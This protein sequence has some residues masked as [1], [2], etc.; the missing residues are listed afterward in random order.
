LRALIRLLTYVRGAWVTTL[1]AYAC[2]VVNGVTTL[3]VPWLLGVA[4]DAGISQNDLGKVAQVSLGILG[5][6]ALRGLA[7]FG[8]GYLAESSAQRVS[9]LLR[10][11]LYVHLQKLSFSFHDQAQTGELMSRTTADVEAVRNFTG[12]G[13]LNLANI[14]VLMVGVLIALLSMNTILA[15]VSLTIIPVLVW[16]TER[17]TRTIR[18]MQT[19][20]QEGLAAVATR[21]QEAV[22]GVRVVKA[23]GREQYEIESFEAENNALFDKYL[24]AA[25]TTALNAPLLDFLSSASTLGMLWLSALLVMRGQLT[26]GEMVAFYSYLLQLVQPIRRAGSLMVMASRASASAQRVFEVLDTPL[27]VADKP[28][29][30]ILRGIQGR[31]EFR[32][33]SCAYYPGRPVLEQVSFRAEPDQT[34]ALVGSTGSGKTSVANLIPRFYDVSAGAV[35]IDD[36]DVRDVRLRS[37]RRQIGVVLQETLLFSGSVRENIAFGRP[38]A[39]D[40]EI[41]AAAR[42]ARAAEFIERLP[43][44]YDTPVGE[45][46]GSLS[47]GQKQRIAIAR[48]ILMDPRILILD[49]FTSAV[50]L[51]TEKLIRGALRELMHKRTTFVIAHRLATVRS[52][53]LILV[54]ERGRIVARGTHAE[55]LQNSPEYRDI[56]SAQLEAE[57]QHTAAAAEAPQLYGPPMEVLLP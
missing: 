48:A 8:Q 15:V 29:A 47:G 26:F 20:V 19:A 39:S 5:V 57:E 37:L 49:E 50:D 53:D 3:A 4:I 52:A 10:N 27:T 32:G 46:G 13:M 43:R 12:R 9:Y 18:P 44:G 21:V 1:G 33:V 16:R 35:L 30:M 14:A 41:S 55:L 51:E 25:R 34:I 7:A 36:H 2:L 38:G 28:D 6:S 17:F 40:A 22:A 54:L 24:V 45:R 56:Y 11:A 31:V 42:A 23:F